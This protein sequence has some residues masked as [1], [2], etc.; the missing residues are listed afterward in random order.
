M[1]YEYK[2]KEVGNRLQLLRKRQG[3][4]Q[5]EMA[6]KLGVTIKHYGAVERGTTGFSIDCWCKV[7]SYYGISLDYFI[8]GDTVGKKSNVFLRRYGKRLE[9]LTRE[10][11][12]EFDKIMSLVLR[13]IET[14]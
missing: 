7:C 4:T 10:E 5:Q 1:S 12:N 3:L 6:D 9:R 2:A 8:F 13:G 11:Y 14:K